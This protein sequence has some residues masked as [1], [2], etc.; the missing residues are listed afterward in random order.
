MDGERSQALV[1][2][3]GKTRHVGAYPCFRLCG[4]VPGF[5]E[6]EY[7]ECGVDLWGAGAGVAP[8]DHMDGADGIEKELITV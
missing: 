3:L 4:I 5:D 8:V 2:R 7:Q 1:V 6:S